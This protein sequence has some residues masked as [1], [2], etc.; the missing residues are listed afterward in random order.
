MKQTDESAL[1]KV[2]IETPKG[3]CEKFAYDKRSG[4]FM[5]KKILPP[6]MV[7]PY[8][9]GFIP[10]TRGKDG[11]PLDILVLSEFHSFPGCMME[12]RLLGG[13]KARQG[14]DSKDMIRNDRYIAI[15]RESKSY[16]DI[17]HIDHLPAPMIR[18]LED[19]FINYNK[20][21]GKLFK[22]LGYVSSGKAWKQINACR[23]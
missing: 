20:E 13:I 6:G 17:A 4:F 14:H 16:N 10:D 1:L 15:P 2:V 11:D 21:E 19:F 9:F 5:L 12:C 3:S 18:S 23:L 7:F 22:P 8:D